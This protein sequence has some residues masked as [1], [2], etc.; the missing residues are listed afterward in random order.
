MA[1]ATL[2]AVLVMIVSTEMRLAIGAMYESHP[3]RASHFTMKEQMEG[4]A[5]MLACSA[6]ASQRGH[7]AFRINSDTGACEMGDLAQDAEQGG[8]SNCA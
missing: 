1:M 3:M 4:L 6:L 8:N 5:S 7:K 2:A